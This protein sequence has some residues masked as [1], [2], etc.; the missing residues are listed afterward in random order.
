VHESYFDDIT[1]KPS[2]RIKRIP[3]LINYVVGK[4]G[5][6]KEPDLEDLQTISNPPNI[7]SEVTYTPIEYIKGDMHRAGYHFGMDYV[8]HFFDRR[9]FVIAL[10]I[11]KHLVDEYGNY[12]LFVFTSILSRITRMNR[13]IPKKNGSGVVGPCLL[14]RSNEI[15]SYTYEKS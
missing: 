5:F 15:R 14:C 4:R 11:R 1:G 13:F 9:V 3:V 7:S 8:H 2:V 12:G 10:D 6:E